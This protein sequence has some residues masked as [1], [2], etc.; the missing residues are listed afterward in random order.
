MPYADQAQREQDHNTSFVI[1]NVEEAATESGTRE[2]V[3]V[4]AGTYDVQILLVRPEVY[5]DKKGF[6][7]QMLPLEI[8]DGEYEGE[9]IRIYLWLN[10]QDSA[11]G[12]KRDGVSKSKV[13]RLAKA[14]DIGAMKDFHDIKGKFVTVQYGENDRGYLEILDVSAYGNGNRSNN[15]ETQEKTEVKDDIPF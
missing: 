1:S 10:N 4:P 3:K 7:Q 2:K 13:A 12:K 6:N 15:P 9:W 8:I 11:D 14:L 5:K